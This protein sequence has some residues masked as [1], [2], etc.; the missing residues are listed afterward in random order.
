MEQTENPDLL[1]RLVANRSHIETT[2]GGQTA[3]VFA[4]KVPHAWN[5]TGIARVRVAA[6]ETDH[7]SRTSR[8]ERRNEHDTDAGTTR[9]RPDD[10]DEAKARTRTPPARRHGATTTTTGGTNGPGR[11]GPGRR[12]D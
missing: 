5:A 3:T 9:D 8:P 10:R 11:A 6:R 2:H 7:L 12:D 1:H 4:D